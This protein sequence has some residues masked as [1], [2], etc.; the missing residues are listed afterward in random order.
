MT[1]R[2]CWCGNKIFLP[3]NSE[4]GE[5]QACRTLV[6]LKDMPSEQFLVHDDETDYYGKKYW[7]E[8][9]QDDF[10]YADI[11]TR[12][13]NDL[14]ERNLYWL[15]TLLKYCLPPA[16]V[17][18]LGCSHGSFVALMGQAGY[19][20]FGVEMS[21][22]VVE[23]GHK[24][25]DIPVAVGP[26]EDLDIA[27]GSLEVVVLMDVLEHL[28]EPVATMT[29]CL[30]LLKPDGLLL[31]QT[32]QFREGMNYTELVETKGAF[33]EQLKVDE[34]LYL[35]SENSVTQLFNQLGAEYI[36]FEPAIFAHYD[37][38]FAVS[39]APLKVNT[40]EQIEAVLLGTPKGR[41]A[42]ALL[43]IDEHG[44]ANNM[45]N[46]CNLLEAQ[47][48]DLQHNFDVVEKDY[49]LRSE[50]IESQGQVISQLQGQIDEFLK[51]LSELYVRTNGLQNERNLLEAQLA[52]LQHNFDAVEK[53]GAARLEVIESQGQQLG[54]MPKLE[55]DINYLIAQLQASVAERD[56]LY[57]TKWVK[58]GLKAK[59]LRPKN[60]G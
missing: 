31:I 33:L 28:P 13:R 7:L 60:N 46:E 22:W 52:D 17:L 36:Q 15:K 29:H 32:P 25:F 23:F 57:A 55:A 45:Q 53:D 24:T 1:I 49:V 5:C 3:F 11:H 20:A 21:P 39:R 48:A 12:S 37:M 8:H 35:F 34:H 2:I 38:F 51:E 42:L 9:Q 18:E 56:A 41:I 47:M 54:L 6:F 59:L 14:T 30:S 58:M 43:D 26:I 50:V 4:Y 44:R 27:L 40:S 16:K 10:G 19:D